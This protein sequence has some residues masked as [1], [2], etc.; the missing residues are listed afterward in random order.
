[1][2][3]HRLI[4]LLAALLGTLALPAL[5]AGSGVAFTLTPEQIAWQEDKATQ[6]VDVHADAAHHVVTRRIRIAPGTD[7]PPHGH[8]RGYRLVTVVSGTLLLGFGDR[9]DAAVL[10]PMPPGSVFSEEAGHKHFA[11]TLQEPVVLQLTEVSL[12]CATSAPARP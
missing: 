7:L 10:Q 11:R 6:R 3:N 1:M 12:P 9:F 4:P 5:A 2:P 8:E